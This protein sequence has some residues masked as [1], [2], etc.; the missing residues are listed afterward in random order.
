M[1]VSCW[2]W[3]WSIKLIIPNFSWRLFQYPAIVFGGL[4]VCIRSETVATLLSKNFECLHEN[5]GKSFILQPR[6]LYEP[7]FLRLYLWYQIKI[8]ETEN[9]F[10]KFYSWG[11]GQILK[12]LYFC[13]GH[14]Q[15]YTK[16]GLEYKTNFES[17]EV[18]KYLTC[19]QNM[20]M[21][22]KLLA[23]FSN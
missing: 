3:T 5:R 16:A 8:H 10:R 11:H 1:T 23:K 15:N 17:H 14:H 21:K 9:I 7:L 18:Q 19:N 20:L 6:K 22:S 2:K 13:S 12:Y 4:S